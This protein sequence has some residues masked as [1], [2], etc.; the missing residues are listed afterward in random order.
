M[1]LKVGKLM[2]MELAL[3][4]IMEEKLPF[5]LSYKLARIARTIEKETTIL[6]NTQERL[7]RQ[8]GMN[9]EKNPDAWRILPENREVFQKEMRDA[10]EIVVNLDIEKI[11]A[12]EIEGTVT[13]GKAIYVLAELIDMA[14]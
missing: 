1:E 10:A 2:D 8:Y 7:F 13:K 12:I 4:D 3:K 14:E 5:R 6:K 11:P 9:D